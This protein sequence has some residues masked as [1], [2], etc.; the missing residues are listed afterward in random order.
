MLAALSY[1]EVLTVAQQAKVNAAGA[2]AEAAL[3]GE[4]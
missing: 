1:H 4:R 3:P 2:E